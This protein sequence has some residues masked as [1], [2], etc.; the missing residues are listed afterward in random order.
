MSVIFPLSFVTILP[1]SLHCSKMQEVVK[2]GVTSSFSTNSRG[3]VLLF[4]F[5]LSYTIWDRNLDFFLT[6]SR[7]KG[8]T[9]WFLIWL[10]LNPS[11]EICQSTNNFDFFF[12]CTYS[13]LHLN[14]FKVTSI[15]LWWP[16]CFLH[17]CL[18]LYQTRQL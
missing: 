2:F 4:N 9:L 12:N 3:H 13:L 7:I 15:S 16:N 10:I 11:L 1:F 5:T 14:L 17:F 8:Q 18:N 6:I